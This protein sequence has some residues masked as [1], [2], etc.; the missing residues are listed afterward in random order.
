MPVSRVH[1]RAV[2]MASSVV[3]WV[4]KTSGTPLPSSVRWMTWAMLTPWSAMQPARS[5]S[6]PGSSSTMT[7]T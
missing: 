3:S 2:L 6:T 7:R 4:M 1:C 5:R